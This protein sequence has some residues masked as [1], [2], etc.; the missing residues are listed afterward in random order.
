MGLLLVLNG[1]PQGACIPL[2]RERTFLGRGGHCD[3]IINLPSASREHACITRKE[4]KFFIADLKS[5]NGTAVNGQ[6]I[7]PEA[8]FPLHDNDK[9]KICDFLCSFH[10]IGRA[11]V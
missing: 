6:L 4:S 10:Q 8:P 3:V 5:R 1:T 9:I 7:E 2:E 11:H